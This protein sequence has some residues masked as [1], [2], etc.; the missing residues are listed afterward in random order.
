MICYY[1]TLME[2]ILWHFILNLPSPDS[3]GYLAA[4]SGDIRLLIKKTRLLM[5][6][7]EKLAIIIDIIIEYH[8]K[9]FKSRH[10][11]HNPAL[12]AN[13]VR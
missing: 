12:A 8:N 9:C 10:F 13:L 4:G 5:T 3:P 2:M 11:L 6:L 1:P 7:I